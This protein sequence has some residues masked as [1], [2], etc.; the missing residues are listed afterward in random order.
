MHAVCFAFNYF[1]IF[2]PLYIFYWQYECLSGLRKWA[3]F[4]CTAGSMIINT[5]PAHYWSKWKCTL[6]PDQ[7]WICNCIL[8]NW[9]VWC[10]MLSLASYTS[11]VWATDRSVLIQ[12]KVKPVEGDNIWASR[13]SG[14]K[15]PMEKILNAFE[16]AEW[17]FLSSRDCDVSNL[18]LCPKNW[19]YH[20]IKWDSSSHNLFHTLFSVV[21]TA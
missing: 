5:R 15:I 6:E 19:I 9:T 3:C 11:F 18:R 21:I 10:L 2:E 8:P 14:T 17:G 4:S 1:S 7:V 16:E 13:V 20:H 12:H